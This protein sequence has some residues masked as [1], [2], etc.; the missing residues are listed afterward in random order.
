VSGTRLNRH[1]AA[2]IAVASVAAIGAATATATGAR[3]EA[4][5]QRQV[6]GRSVEGRAIVARRAGDPGAGFDVLVVGSI[7]GDER[8]GRRIV[9]RIRRS[10]RRGI[11]GADLWTITTVNPDGAARRARK[12]AHGVDLNRNFPVGFDPHLDGGYESGPHPFSE[13]ESRAVAR[14]SKRVRFDLAIWYH[15][16]WNVVLPPCNRDGRTARLY[17][18]LS[19][20]PAKHRCD[21]YAPGSAIGWQHVKL[22]TDAFV[23]ELPGRGLHSREVRRHARAV[24]ALVRRLR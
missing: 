16:P 7:H 9:R 4:A 3:F 21:R 1:A 12:N 5:A 23:A 18:R 14:L 10:H 8:Q 13:P 22:G 11:R 2:L 20:L 19:G 24:A 6:I 15:Q 17:A